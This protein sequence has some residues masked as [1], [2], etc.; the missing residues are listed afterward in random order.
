MQSRDRESG[1]TLLELMVVI[2]VIAILITIA[3]PTF[4]GARKPAQDRQ[5]E[6]IL[7][8]SLVAARVGA[9]D[10]GD[11]SW[12]TPGALQVLET[13]VAYLDPATPADAG[14]HEV[15]VGTGVVSGS[16]YVIMVSRSA[17]GRC[18][19]VFEQG[20]AATQYLAEV[21]PSCSAAAFDPS[22]SWSATAW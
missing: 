7:H 9:A 13:S 5:A 15:S 22:S 4:L 8:T 6:T 2:A 10:T 3:I 18:F 19:G 1:F 11:Y 17:A 21:V 20:A 16:T 12:V 14:S